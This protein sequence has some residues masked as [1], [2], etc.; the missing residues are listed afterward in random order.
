MGLPW[1]GRIEVSVEPLAL[2][3]ADDAAARLYERARRHAAAGHTAAIVTRLDGEA[4]R[5]LL[6]LDD[7]AVEGALGDA[8][9]DERF[10]REAREAMATGVSPTLFLESPRAVVEVPGPPA[11]L[12][13]VGAGH[14]AVPLV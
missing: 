6:G 13:V 8:F 12:L 9:L 2:D 4:G 14:V 7:G 11:P 1:G 5:K 10:S 3:R